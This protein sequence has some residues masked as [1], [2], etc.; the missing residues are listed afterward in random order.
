MILRLIGAYVEYVICVRYPHCKGVCHMIGLRLKELRIKNNMT[1]ADVSSHLQV[2]RGTYSRYETGEREMTY[3]TLASLSL[4][5][6]VSVGYL[7]GLHENNP[8][9]NDTETDLLHK[10]RKLD[11]RGQKTVKAIIEHEYFHKDERQGEKSQ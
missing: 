7:L 1:Q 2:A 8:L 10:F 5:F 11:G 4:L 3:E 6:Q 9:L